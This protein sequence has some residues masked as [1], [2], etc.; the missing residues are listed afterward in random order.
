MWSLGVCI[1]VQHVAVISHIHGED[2]GRVGRSRTA[3]SSLLSFVSS[4]RPAYLGPSLLLYGQ[5]SNPNCFNSYELHR[6][7]FDPN[8]EKGV[9]L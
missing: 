8:G 7:I 1:V 5:D 9:F 6:Y 4:W 3:A 2:V